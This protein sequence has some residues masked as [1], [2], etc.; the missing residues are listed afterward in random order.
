MKILSPSW[1]RESIAT[2]HKYFSNL[3]YVVCESQA[4][5]YKDHGLPVLVCPDNVQGNVS[6]VRNWILD[7]AGKDDVLIVDDDLK[8]LGVWNGNV[9]KKMPKEEVDE[10]IESGFVLAKEFG[11]KLWGVNLIQDKGAFREYTPFSLT[12]VILGPFG[13]FT[14]CEC[15]YDEKLPLKED[16]DLSLQLLNKYRKILRIN[17][18][19]YVCEQHTNLGGCAEY[20]TI[21]AEKDQFRD[22]EKKWGTSIVR[23]DNGEANTQRKRQ[24]AYDI[25]PIIKIPIGGV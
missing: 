1:K 19:H 4:Q 3:K 25:N 20:R 16:Y 15:R 7:Y 22:L 18:V 11:V 6:R 12:N 21:N 14:N 9:H 2:S 8:Y 5:S 10:F 23:R 13:G 17:N 24:V